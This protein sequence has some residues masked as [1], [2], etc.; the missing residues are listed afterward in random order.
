[1]PFCFC[2]IVKQLVWNSQIKGLV[3]KVKQI[4]V[5]SAWS[6]RCTVI[7]AGNTHLDAQQND[8]RNAALVDESVTKWRQK[9]PLLLVKAMGAA[10]APQ[11]NSWRT[12]APRGT[13]RRTAQSND[14]VVVIKPVWLRLSTAPLW[15]DFTSLP[16][17]HRTDKITSTLSVNGCSFSRCFCS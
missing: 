15:A 7:S 5:V 1:M 2:E 17:G 4:Y 8:S 9:H 14:R 6:Q 10:A 13:A 16:L 11:G 12:E 3:L